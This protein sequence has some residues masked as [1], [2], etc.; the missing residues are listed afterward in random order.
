[1]RLHDGVIIIRAVQSRLLMV[2]VGGVPPDGRIDLD[3]DDVEHQSAT[4]ETASPCA[5]SEVVGQPRYPPVALDYTNAM[6][7]SQSSV[8]DTSNDGPI[9]NDANGASSQ[10]TAPGVSSSKAGTDKTTWALNVQRT[11][12]DKLVDRMREELK[13][14]DQIVEDDGD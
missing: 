6:D 14:K 12:L 2:L 1:M 5:I 3:A 10:S 11:K 13:D 4:S 8:D 9:S 7:F